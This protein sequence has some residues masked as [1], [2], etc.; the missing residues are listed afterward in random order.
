M[1]HGTF[2]YN[3]DGIA[4]EYTCRHRALG[5]PCPEG[6]E[7]VRQMMCDWAND[8]PGTFKVR[9]AKRNR[10]LDGNGDEHIPMFANQTKGN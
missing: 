2:Q 6:C 9:L 1:R 4:V 8:L 10:M 5:M 7:V 3:E